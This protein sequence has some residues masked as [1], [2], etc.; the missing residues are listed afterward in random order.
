MAMLFA[1]MWLL[2]EG[3]GGWA[4]FMVVYGIFVISTIDN[5]LK[6][7]LISR[8]SRL[9]F[10]F[11]LVGVFGG[12]LAFGVVGVFIGPTLLALAADVVAHWLGPDEPNPVQGAP[13]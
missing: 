6:P 10:V 8:V 9:P 4:L 2:H 12:V 13:P 5:V 3:Q 7:L 1:S 11:A